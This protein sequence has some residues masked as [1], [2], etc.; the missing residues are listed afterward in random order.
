MASKDLQSLLKDREHIETLLNEVVGQNLFE[1]LRQLETCPSQTPINDLPHLRQHKKQGDFAEYLLP[2]AVTVES[3]TNYL[4][5]LH[6]LL[7]D[8]DSEV[9]VLRS[10]TNPDRPS[11]KYEELIPDV[12]QRRC[13]PG[14]NSSSPNTSQVHRTGHEESDAPNALFLCEPLSLDQALKQANNEIINKVDCNTYLSPSGHE[15]AVM[16]AMRL[17]DSI[18]WT[19]D[20]KDEFTDVVFTEAISFRPALR[21]AIRQGL[22]PDVIVDNNGNTLMHLALLRR[23]NEF[24]ECYL[25]LV[26]ERMKDGFSGA[27]MT[28]LTIANRDGVTI[29]QTAQRIAA[30]NGVNDLRARWMNTFEYFAVVDENF[31]M[32]IQA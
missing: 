26:S 22:Y 13:E 23:H 6:C 8:I 17:G 14:L 21:S 5:F 28:A 19:D 12:F 7:S 29:R 31:K 24:A 11:Q 2:A 16:A 30:E 9:H 20:W 3:F 1:L 15:D 25:E 10:Q 32:M 18:D 27:L 4:R